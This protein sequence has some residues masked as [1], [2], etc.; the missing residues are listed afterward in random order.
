MSNPSSGR[1]LELSIAN[2]KQN[3]TL[4]RRQLQTGRIDPRYFEQRLESLQDL[5]V[6]LEADRK[7]TREQQRVAALYEVSK[8]IG[9][10]LNLQTVLD[11]VMDAIIQLTAAERGFLML[12]DDDGNLDVKVARDFDQ[13]TLS[14]NDIAFSRTITHQVFETGEGVLTTNAQEDPRYAGQAS[15]IAHAMRSIMAAPLRA[16]GT[17]IGVVY[18]DNRIRAGLFGDDDL[19]ALQAF[20]TQAA[21]AIENARLYSE[22]DAQLQA[23]LEEIQILQWIDRQLN[24]SLDPD[25]TIHIL[26]EWA[27]RLGKADASSV[28]MIDEDGHIL[29]TA[30]Y[31]SGDVFTVGQVIDPAVPLVRR[32][33]EVEDAVLDVDPDRQQTLLCIPIRFE[34][35]VIA[36]MFFSALR[37][38]AFSA[39]EQTILSRVASRAATALQNGRLYMAVKAA[40]RAKT[41][42]VSV[43]AHELKVPMTSIQGYASMLKVVGQLN[44]QQQQFVQTVVNNVERMKIL[45]NDL[46]DISRIESGQLHID[47][48]PIELAPVLEQARDGVMAQVQERGHQYIEDIAAD[49]PNVHADPARLVQI[50]VNLL[51]NAYKYTPDNGTITLR[52]QRRDAA[53][54]ISIQDTGVGM[55]PEQL[56]KLGT[57]FVRFAD[58]DHVAK[59]SGTGLGFAI[60]RNLIQLM[61]GELFIESEVGM[62]STFTFTV[63][64]AEG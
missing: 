15:I 23:R 47:I 54:Y 12:L 19:Q 42:F 7:N 6:D 14:S 35:A 2:A 61:Q 5:L 24:S 53:V 56:A 22:T 55:S 51:S 31:G 50:L 11:Q 25:R 33:L 59:Q 39:E 57:K 10:S 9:S 13:S 29:I 20:A 46:S 4:L 18:V 30:I 16:R 44:D 52:V 8:V 49:L 3:I 21:V 17:T 1:E 45:V 58:N 37:V 40:D 34:N 60:T 62:G 36:L 38:D 27:T 63:P 64:I 28:G 26:L 43:V 41:E 48:Q 32:A